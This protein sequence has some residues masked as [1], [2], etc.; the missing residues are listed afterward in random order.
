MTI[1]VGGRSAWKIVTL[2]VLSGSLSFRRTTW[3]STD[4]STYQKE[5]ISDNEE[6][7]TA[8]QHSKVDRENGGAGLLYRNS[9]SYI[10][11]LLSF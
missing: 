3:S 6:I 1:V 10:C 8:M 9:W 7:S 4:A 5:E 2:F 11:D